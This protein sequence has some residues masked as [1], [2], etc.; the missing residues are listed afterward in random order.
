MVWQ[1]ATESLH[2]IVDW[3][4]ILLVG[5]GVLKVVGVSILGQVLVELN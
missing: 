1:L 2:D 5:L 3:Q 4:F